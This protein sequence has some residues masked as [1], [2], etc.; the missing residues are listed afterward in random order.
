MSRQHLYWQH[1]ST[2]GISQL[3]LTRLWPNF[4]GRILGP[5]L[6]DANCYGHI[7]SGNI[8]PVDICPY[9]QYFS[10]YWT[11]FNKTFW[12][13]LFWGHNFC[14][15]KCSW[16]KFLRAQFFVNTKFFSRPEILLEPKVFFH[17]QNFFQTQN[18]ESLQAE[19][20]R[21]KSCIDSS[22]I[23]FDSI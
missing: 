21:L 5:S 13:K 2:S 4:K 1:L 16:T 22:L 19:N 9:N 18:L 3:S 10:C 11:G 7:C 17:A 23:G 6:Q 12:T 20:F 15:L 14:G 8:C